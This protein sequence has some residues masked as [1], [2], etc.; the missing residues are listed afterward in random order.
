MR[1]GS[2]WGDAD[3]KEAA[4]NSGRDPPS[5]LGET[6]GVQGFQWEKIMHLNDS[7]GFKGKEWDFMGNSKMWFD[8]V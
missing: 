4:R 8:D 1:V 3:A 2:C 5:V 6:G 7:T